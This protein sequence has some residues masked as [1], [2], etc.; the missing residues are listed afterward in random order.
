MKRAAIVIFVLLAAIF[1]PLLAGFLLHSKSITAL[2]T[3]LFFALAFYLVLRNEIVRVRT[4]FAVSLVGVAL[5]A[6]FTTLVM[7]TIASAYDG[8]SFGVVLARTAANLQAPE[9]VLYI[10]A[11]A[12][13]ILLPLLVALWLSRVRR[14]V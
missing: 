9:G 10:F 12:G 2:V 1:I 6:W 8:A 4:L 14:A 3:A 13:M 11:Y 7:H 5:G